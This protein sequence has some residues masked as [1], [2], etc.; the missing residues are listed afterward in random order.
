M[1]NSCWVAWDQATHLQGLRVSRVIHTQAHCDPAPLT[2]LELS[3]TNRLAIGRILVLLV[4]IC[5]L[6]SFFVVATLHGALPSPVLF[7]R[8]HRDPYPYLPPRFLCCT[9]AA[10]FSRLAASAVVVR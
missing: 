8:S 1:V 5:S 6:V 3:A 4:P 7:C 9:H 10:S 2:R